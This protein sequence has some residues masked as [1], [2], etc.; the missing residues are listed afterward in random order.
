MVL[1]RVALSKWAMVSIKKSKDAWNFRHK[2][3]SSLIVGGAAI[4]RQ[5][6][7]SRLIWLLGAWVGPPPQ[8]CPRD[9]EDEITATR[10]SSTTVSRARGLSFQGILQRGRIWALQSNH[11]A[12]QEGVISSFP[13]VLKG[14][15]ERNYGLWRIIKALLRMREF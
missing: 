4:P 9:K 15:C 10:L 7:L 5:F 3:L 12:I 6:Q 14:G 1:K 13:E 2:S 8:P 11:W